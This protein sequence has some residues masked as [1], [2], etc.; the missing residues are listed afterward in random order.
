[1]Q[2]AHHTTLCGGT[3]LM[4]AFIRSHY[5]IRCIRAEARRIVHRCVKCIRQAGMTSKQIMGDLPIDRLRPARPFVKTGVDLAGPINIRA[6]E[7]S[8]MITRNSSAVL[9]QELKGYVCIFVCLVTRAVHLEPVMDISAEAFLAAYK[10]FT[11]RRG[12]SEIIYSDNGTNF[13]RADKDLKMAVKS[14]QENSVQDYISWNGTQWNFITP[15]A[16]HQG[17]LWEAAVKR[18]KLHLKKIMGAEKYSYEALSTLLADIEACLNSRP[19]CAM[20]D[21]PNDMIAL[22]P[23]HF[24]IGEPLKLPLPERHDE[25]PKMAVGF[26]KQLQ[27][28]TNSFWKVWSE[29]YLSTLMERPKWKLEQKNLRAGNLVLIK[30]ENLAPTYWPMGRVISVKKGADGC[31]R[32]AK[33]KVGSVNLDRPIQKL[34]VLP[35]DEELENYK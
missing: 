35:V 11:A 7:K 20:S 5:W 23:S 10:R 21:D 13:V 16:P 15:S 19:I 25:P 29:D 31:V 4:M 17:G 9:N 27:A 3:Q 12:V 22:T 14:W 1:M 30:N 18:M 28:I 32:E 6:V 24:L 2:Q 33:I 8:R 26:Y 34:V